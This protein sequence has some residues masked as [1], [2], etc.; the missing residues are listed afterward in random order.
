MELYIVYIYKL[1]PYYKVF[2]GEIILFINKK[3]GLKGKNPKNLLK[4][5]GKITIL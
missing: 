5:Y 1:N 4:L 2:L 3:G